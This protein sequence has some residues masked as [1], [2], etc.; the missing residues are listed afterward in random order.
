MRFRRRRWFFGS[1]RLCTR[2]GSKH[3]DRL[4]SEDA[5]AR[6]IAIVIPLARVGLLALTP[7]RGQRQQKSCESQPERY[8]FSPVIARGSF[9][10]SYLFTESLGRRAR[11]HPFVGSAVAVPSFVFIVI[12]IFILS[13]GARGVDGNVDQ[14]LARLPH[15]LVA[16]PFVEWVVEPDVFV[17]ELVVEFGYQLRIFLFARLRD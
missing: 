7:Y 10:I 17:V 5:S 6:I 2:S 16:L 3:C 13:I 12:F 14:I 11:E 4:E 9:F 8:P 15:Y 1:W